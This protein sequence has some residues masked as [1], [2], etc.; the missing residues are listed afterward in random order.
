VS[1]SSPVEL[2]R[3]VLEVTEPAAIQDA[4]RARLSMNLLRQ[5][6]CRFALDD[7][8][9]GF[10]SFG[11]LRSLPVDLLKIDG[12]FIRNL[13]VDPVNQHLVRAMVEVARGL[14]KKTVAE[15]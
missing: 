10:S 9:V 1:R 2:S 4:S 5:A 15:F 8:G 12:S 11:V 6:G 13:V 3:L 14:G 7:F